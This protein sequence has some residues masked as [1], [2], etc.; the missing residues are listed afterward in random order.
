LKKKIALL[1]RIQ[2]LGQRHCRSALAIFVFVCIF[3][4][5]LFVTLPLLYARVKLDR[6]FPALS[7][8]EFE[9]TPDVALVGSSITFRL[10]EGYFLKTR[11]RNIAIGGGSALTGLAIIASY[12]KLPRLIF[13]ETNI[14]SRPVDEA[15]VEQFGRNDAESYQWFRPIR[16]II[17]FVY[18]WIKYKSEAENVSQLPREKPLDYDISASVA[19]T[20]EE[21][22][23]A[24]LD[25]TMVRNAEALKRL[26]G[27]LE[28]RGCQIFFYELPYPDALGNTHYAV[29]ARSFVHTV[30]SDS[31][32]WPRLDF[33]EQQ[34]RWVDAAHMDERSAIIVAQEIERL[35]LSVK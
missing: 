8:Y 34:L 3:V 10:F 23:S 29:T 33:R 13:V 5:W 15:L 11:P 14:L 16:A 27:N 18:Y 26:I 22:N 4:G 12:Q 25:D 21:Y 31:K 17:S 20:L 2:F 35:M 28:D 30:F 24:K 19:T 9:M 7:R 6:S 32:Q 1:S